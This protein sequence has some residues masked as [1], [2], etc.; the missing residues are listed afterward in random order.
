MV[1]FFCRKQAIAR[2][3]SVQNLGKYSSFLL[4]KLKKLLLYQEIIF[5]STFNIRYMNCYLN[6]GMNY[7]EKFSFAALQFAIRRIPRN[8][9]VTAVTSTT[10]KD[11]LLP[12]FRFF[13][14][15][16]LFSSPFSFSTHLY[17]PWPRV[18]EQNSSSPR[19]SQ[20]CP[21]TRQEIVSKAD[22]LSFEL[23]RTIVGQMLLN[24][25]EERARFISSREFS[26]SLYFIS[27]R[28]VFLFALWQIWGGERERRNLI[29]F[30][31]FY[32]VRSVEEHVEDHQR[33]RISFYFYYIKV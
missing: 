13:F 18:V 8:F 9:E 1:S 27:V 26:R 12:S 19:F 31:I 33:S 15:F 10:A 2:Y 4:K 21:E 11:I 28:F 24:L 25:E 14:L 30:R 17:D 7:G 16:T 32:K 5:I 3:F 29:N 20:I 23:Y 22:S 6:S